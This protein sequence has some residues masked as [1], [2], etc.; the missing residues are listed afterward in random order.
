MRKQADAYYVPPASSFVPP[1]APQPQR[2]EARPTFE[3]QSGAGRLLLFALFAVVAA[4]AA[5]FLAGVDSLRSILL[6]MGF[7]LAMWTVDLVFATGFV[8]KWMEQATERRRIMAVMMDAATVNEAQDAAMEVL[9]DE[10]KRLE[11]RLDAMDT[12]E[13]SDGRTA[14]KVHK[15][16]TVDLRLRQW[17][18]TEVFSAS[19]AMVGVHPNG[20]LK[21]AVPFKESA[22][23][24]SEEHT[25][26]RRLVTAGLLGRNGNNYIWTG[27]PTLP[28]ALEKL[29]RLGVQN[30]ANQD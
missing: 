11:R 6:G 23:P 14:R 1:Q 26:Y 30:A 16:D 10:L 12:I 4:L 15:A 8:H 29:A 2:M 18:S 21:R 27:P 25:A 9:W 5:H 20:Q 19:G 13:I 7:L 17:L 28:L 24:G 22:A 3:G